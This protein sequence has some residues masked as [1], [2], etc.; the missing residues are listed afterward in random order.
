LVVNTH[1]AAEAYE[2]VLGARDGTIEW[3][4]VPVV[5]RHEPVLLDTGGGIKNVE[6]L[7]GGG[8]FFVHNGD[9]LADM[10]LGRLWTEHCESG[11]I[12]TLGLRSHGGP[13]HV[14]FDAGSRRVEDIRGGLGGSAAPGHLFT[15]IS[16]VDPALFDHLPGGVAVSVIPAFL[17]LLRSG[18]RVGGVVLDDG[19]WFDLGTRESYIAAHRLLVSGGWT[20]T[21]GAS[22]PALHPDSLVASD[23]VFEGACVIGARA[24]VGA[25]AV[26]R[27]T[28]VWEDAEIAS[29]ARLDGCIVRDHRRA[30]G[31][32]CGVDV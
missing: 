21:Y 11:N 18:Q 24:R 13:L 10:D 26:L 31:C 28:I 7:L 19:L 3:G 14:Q 32:L 15:G 9:V 4:G 30:E 29:R 6:D 17:S 22:L 23:V 20:L 8:P 5:L 27:D 12:V 1:H 25:G 16:V 2:T